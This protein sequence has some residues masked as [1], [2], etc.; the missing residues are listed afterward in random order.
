MTANE[1]KAILVFEK[2]DDHTKERVRKKCIDNG[3]TR[4]ISLLSKFD[5]L[6]Q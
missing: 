3:S 6:A 2:L 5:K 4:A 1:V